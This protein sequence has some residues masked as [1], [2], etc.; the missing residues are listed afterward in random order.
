MKWLSL[1]ATLGLFHWGAAM[2]WAE[3]SVLITGGTGSFGRAFAR[4][5]L[6]ECGPRRL[7]VYSRDELKQYE[8]RE[9][10]QDESDGRIRYFIGDVRDPQRLARALEGVDIVVHAAALKQVTTAE[11]N[12]LEVIKTNV[13]GAANVIDAAIDAKV[14]Q[15]VALST[16]KAA[17]PVN[18]YGAT[19]LCADRLFT[20]AGVYVGA[21]DTSFAVV[22]YGNVV[23]SRGSIIPLFLEKRKSGVVPITDQA[24]TRFWI[25]LNQA[26]RFVLEC[27]ERMSGGEIFVPKLPSMRIVDLASVVAPNCRQEIIGVRPGEKIHEVLLTEDEARRTL[28]F[29]DFYVVLSAL[30]SP[31]IDVDWLAEGH[32]VP[33][34]FVY[35]SD[36]NPT[37]I[38]QQEVLTILKELG[39]RD[40]QE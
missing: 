3:L 8:M 1:F 31:G 5:I 22:R 11:Y 33:D 4:H 9:E 7:I 21:A 37:W 29:D 13:L 26:A 15:V 28:E 40:L 39:A 38:S 18:L 10:F 35:S 30:E 12:P 17:N 16:D 27:I 36:S 24:M 23:G 20:T 14:G 6:R 32:P 34:H 2:D 19:K 25:T